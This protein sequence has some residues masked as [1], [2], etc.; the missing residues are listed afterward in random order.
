MK[1][2]LKQV[3]AHIE[4]VMK[5]ITLKNEELENYHFLIPLI[6][7]AVPLCLLK[8]AKYPLKNM[9]TYDIKTSVSE[10]HIRVINRHLIM[11]N[12]VL[13]QYYDHPLKDMI[14]DEVVEWEDKMKKANMIQLISKELA[15]FKHLL[16][17]LIDYKYN[18][19]QAI[20]YTKKAKEQVY[21]VLNKGE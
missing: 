15:E 2:K 13:V 19:E 8:N 17:E 1:K 20:I 9:F 21:P 10:H 18:L 4:T 14:L 5:S 11:L 3:S 6:P 16:T 12:E 7:I